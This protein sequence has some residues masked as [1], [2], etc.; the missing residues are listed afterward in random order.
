[1]VIRMGPASGVAAWAVTWMVLRAPKKRSQI[2][3]IFCRTSPPSLAKPQYGH[4]LSR[5]ITKG[6]AI[7]GSFPSQSNIAS[8]GQKRPA[9][10]KI[11][12]SIKIAFSPPPPGKVV[13]FK[14]S[15]L[16]C[17]VFPH[18]GPF[19]GWGGGD[20]QILRTIILWTPRLF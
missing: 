17:T 5:Q 18:F 16:I 20:N 15:L 4:I 6:I 13:S 14:D 2:A 3:A 12:L 9:V 8:V 11:V 19:C 1:M 7:A 10:H